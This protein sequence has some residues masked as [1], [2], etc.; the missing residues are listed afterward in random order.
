MGALAGAAAGEARPLHQ[1][2]ARLR[3]PRPQGDRAAP[4]TQIKGTGPFFSVQAVLEAKRRA[5]GLDRLRVLLRLLDPELLGE[6]ARLVHLGDDV[7]AADQLA[8]HEELRD[9]R[10]ARE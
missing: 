9:R 2:G 1:A 10:P 6:L 8:V 5:L 7:A 4:Q 3:G